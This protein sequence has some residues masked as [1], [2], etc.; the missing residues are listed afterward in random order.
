MRQTTNSRYIMIG[1]LI[2]ITSLTIVG[3]V[4]ANYEAF[5]GTSDSNQ[6]HSATN[7]CGNKLLPN[8]VLCSNT[9]SQ[10]QGDEN[11]VVITS[12]QEAASAVVDGIVDGFLT[13]K[14]AII[15]PFGE[16]NP[17]IGNT[18]GGLNAFLITHGL[19]PENGEGRR[20]W[21]RSTHN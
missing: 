18:M 4:I 6:G 5:A 8:N 11:A 16:P 7:S 17:P 1:A 3:S 20:I 12:L 15:K 21:I 2:A 14:E 10:V 19:I 13:I 9:D